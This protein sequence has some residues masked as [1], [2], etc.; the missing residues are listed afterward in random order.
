MT[1]LAEGVMAEEYLFGDSQTNLRR[2]F[3]AGLQSLVARVYTALP[4]HPQ[5]NGTR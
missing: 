4:R 5:G 2:G 1:A 3:M